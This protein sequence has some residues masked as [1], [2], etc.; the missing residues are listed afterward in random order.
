MIKSSTKQSQIN[1]YPTIT[2]TNNNLVSANMTVARLSL[3]S[4]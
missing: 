1:T 3:I 4:L 2:Q